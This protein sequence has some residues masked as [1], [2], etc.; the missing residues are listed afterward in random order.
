[1]QYDPKDYGVVQAANHF[2]AEISLM[3]YVLNRE[4]YLICDFELNV[5]NLCK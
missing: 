5:H 4:S 3:D 1:M 2:V